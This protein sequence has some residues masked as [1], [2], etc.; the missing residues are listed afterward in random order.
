MDGLYWALLGVFLL[1]IVVG[2]LLV[3]LVLKRRREHTDYLAMFIIGLIWFVA[4]IPLKIWALSIL[5]AGF[6]V[7]GLINR[8]FWGKNRM[9]W[10]DL[11]KHEKSVRIVLLIFLTLILVLGIIF[12]S[13]L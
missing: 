11:D 13:L 8:Q 1:I 4:G 9:K 6:A 5:G 2:I 10:K 7:V 3:S 12:Y